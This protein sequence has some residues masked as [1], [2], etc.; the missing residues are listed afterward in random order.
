MKELVV[1]FEGMDR[2]FGMVFNDFWMNMCVLEFLI[3]SVSG[4]GSSS[5]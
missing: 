1:I 5:F 2:V 4:G 3:K